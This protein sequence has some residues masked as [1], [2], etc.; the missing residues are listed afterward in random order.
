[1]ELNNRTTPP[2]PLD[3]FSELI[4]LEKKLEL[5]KEDALFTLSLLLKYKEIK[6]LMFDF[7]AKKIKEIEVDI[8]SDVDV[9]EKLTAFIYYSEITHLAKIL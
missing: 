6:P 8:N 5:K 7:W 1:M 3:D 4:Y 2:E 9:A